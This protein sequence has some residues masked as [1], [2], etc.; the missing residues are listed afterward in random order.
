[1]VDNTG[2]PVSLVD[3]WV[4]SYLLNCSVM[5]DKDGMSRD[6]LQD[7]ADREWAFIIE[8]ATM[9]ILWREF[10]STGGGL[11]V[12]DYAAVQGL[13]EICKPQYLN[14]Q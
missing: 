8:I 2:D 1:M 6:L 12:E 5:H 11:F 9:K 3:N 4:A 13:V 7:G 14:C 10:G